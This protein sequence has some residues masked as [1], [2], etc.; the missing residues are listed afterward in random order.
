MR[1]LPLT[2]SILAIQFIL[3]L[4]FPMDIVEGNW[5]GVVKIVSFIF[6]QF[7]MFAIS[8]GVAN[9]QEEK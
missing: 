8:V 9:R 7:M 6:I 1:Y 2:V 4:H 5:E 3:F